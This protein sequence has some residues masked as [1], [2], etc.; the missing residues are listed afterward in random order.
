MNKCVVVSYGIS[1]STWHVVVLCIHTYL[2]YPGQLALPSVRTPL[3]T[4]AVVPVLFHRGKLI[5]IGIILSYVV[6]QVPNVVFVRRS[7]AATRND[8]VQPAKQLQTAGLD[9]AP[10]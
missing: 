4:Q 8:V 5:G 9:E 2:R 10:P 7:G 1:K 3:T 6:C